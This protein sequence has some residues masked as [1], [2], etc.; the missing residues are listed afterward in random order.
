M[1]IDMHYYGTY[2]MARAAGVEPESAKIIATSAQYV[3]DAVDSS[4]YNCKDGS[5]IVTQATGHHSADI[6]NLLSIDQR[7]VWVPFHFL[8]GNEGDSFQ[9]RL[10]CGKDSAIAK[11]VIERNLMLANK[12]FG[13]ELV[14]ITAHVYADTFSH[15]GFSGI[16][17]PLN[18]VRGESINVE[19]EDPEIRKYITEKAERFFK[20]YGNKEGLWAKI[21]EFVSNTTEALSGAL[22]HGAVATYPDRPYLRWRFEYETGKPISQRDNRA[23]FLYGCEALHGLF[24]QFAAQAPEWADPKGGKPFA[25]IRDTVV[26]ILGVEA[27]QKGRIEAWQGGAREGKLFDPVEGSIPSYEGE[28]WREVLKAY[29]GRPSSDE[30]TGLAVYHFYQAANIHRHTVLRDILP[31]VDLVVV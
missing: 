25:S 15:Y 10:S 4:T 22:G 14:G 19:V 16:S 11:E 18:R 7:N 21:R 17:S 30:A 2:A 1:Q 6:Q 23:T 27:D 26:T 13:R 12:P 31:A 20:K 24:L 29:N 9:E 28:A 8:P 3:D 5:R